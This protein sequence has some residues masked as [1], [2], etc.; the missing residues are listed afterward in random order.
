MQKDSTEDSEVHGAKMS[1]LVIV[2]LLLTIA[3]GVSGDVW[4]NRYL[5][6]VEIDASS[7]KMIEYINYLNTT[8][9]AGRNPGFEDPMYVRGL[10]GVLPDNSRY[11]LPERAVDIRSLG[12]LPED[13][14]SR[15]NWP[16]CPTIREIR[17]QGS[18]GSCWAFGAV[19]AMSDRTCIHSP[20]GGSKVVVHLSADDLISCCR[21]CGMGCQGGYP[22]SAWS[23]W[24]HKGIVTG[25]N[26]DS[27]DGCM[28]YPIKWCDHHI[29]GSLGPC[30]KKVP[31]TPRCVHM[32]R[33]GYGVDYKKDKHYGNSSYS[34]PSVAKQIQAEIMTNGP[35]EADF[36]VY[37]DFVHYKSG[38]Y[39]RHST[40]ALGGHAIRLLGW[41]VE[42]G[43][44]YWLAA[45]SW[46]SEW[47]D[48]GYFKILR[49]SDE[50]GIENDVVAGLPRY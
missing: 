50:C 37:S 6:P 11:R 16:D 17:D 30:D 25:G 2:P 40:Q 43:V 13:F 31:P 36:T 22:G 7:D 15:E 19:E 41:G 42:E 35:V 9:K 33:K 34:V 45:N 14:D 32:C 20:E 44:P 21:S 27:D 24:V 29:N 1:K 10:L 47:G 4:P 28:P 8:W 3:L 12:P 49:G 38:V 5:I 46:N 18:C 48:R 26:Y 23:F 39:K